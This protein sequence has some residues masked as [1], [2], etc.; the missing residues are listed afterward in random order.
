M[1]KKNKIF[2]IGGRGMIG[3]ALQ[4]QLKF[5]SN[6]EIFVLDRKEVDL[7]EKDSQ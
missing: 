7:T 6:I 1:E 2:L 3:K 4:N 5:L